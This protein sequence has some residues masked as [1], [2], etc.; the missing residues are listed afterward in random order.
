[1][2]EPGNAPKP[3]SLDESHALQ[4]SGP[5]EQPIEHVTVPFVGK[6]TITLRATIRA[7]SAMMLSLWHIQSAALFAR[8]SAAIESQVSNQIPTQGSTQYADDAMANEHR[9]CV[10]GAIFLSTAFLEATINELYDSAANGNPALSQLGASTRRDMAILWKHVLMKPSYK[11][12]DK[13]QLALE[14]AG[15]PLLR[16]KGGKSPPPLGSMDD[17]EQLIQLRNALM[18]YQPLWEGDGESGSVQSLRKVLRVRFETRTNPLYPANVNF[19]VRYLAHACAEWSVLASLAF[20]DD[21]FGRLG[22]TSPYEH[23]RS[24]LSTT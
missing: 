4:N 8:R 1:M 14:L 18:H 11:M 6:A 9:T 22:I 23:L 3:A 12:L 24:G 16:K 7:R 21:F 10:T 2:D 17:I 13:Y 15:K 5:L 20:A 19:L